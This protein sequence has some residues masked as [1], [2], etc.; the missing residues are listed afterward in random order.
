MDRYSGTCGFRF[1]QFLADRLT[2]N[3]YLPREKLAVATFVA[4]AAAKR[5]DSRALEIANLALYT[6]ES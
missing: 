6:S 5:N 4:L 2:R 3:N 1:Y